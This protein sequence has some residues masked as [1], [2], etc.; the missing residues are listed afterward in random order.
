MGRKSPLHHLPILIIS[1]A[2]LIA[3]ITFLGPHDGWLKS[4]AAEETTT[5]DVVIVGAGISGL[6]AGDYLHKDYNIVVL[7]K[8][9]RPGG[10]AI[11]GH[12][13]GFTYAKGAEYIGKPYGALKR[14]LSQL[15]IEP[16]EIPSPMDAYYQDGKFY[17]GEEGIALMYID[18]CGLDNFNDFISTIKKYARNYDDIPDF[19][20]NSDLAKLDNISAKSWFEKENFPEIIIERYNIAAR[21]LFGANLGEISALSAIP[22]IAFEYLGSPTIKDVGSLESTAPKG[23]YSTG[24]YTFLGG[25]AEVTTALGKELGDRVWYGKTVTDVSKNYGK[26]VVTFVDEIG[27]EEVVF[28]RVVILA[29]PAP[30][31]LKI[32]PTLIIGEKKAIM[33]KIEYSTYLTVS[34]ISEEPIFEEAFDLAVPDEMFFTDVYDATWVEK[35]YSNTKRKEDVH[36]AVV[37]I[38]P[39]SYK[40]RSL[41]K[42]TDGEVV[43]NVYKDLEKIFPGVRENVIKY[44]VER[45]LY[46]FPVMT[47]GAY[48]RLTRLNLLNTG[49]LLLAG[50]YLIYPT[51]E[52]AVDSGLLAAE[53]AAAELGR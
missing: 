11:S 34:L 26:Y 27:E 36:I 18:K 44:E 40:D 37:Y 3:L 6:T 29:V 52:S 7:E 25:I 20:L 1:V 32:A 31:A 2:V 12:Y 14:I 13:K 41:I 51:I 30:V 46:S 10:R 45:F 22:E 9:Q 4:E 17:F 42:M 5:Y 19:D 23:K 15:K 35:Y 47:P 49:T 8:N 39:K 24:S 50:D 48:R 53:R 33:S 43:D 38:P 16:K 28:G 21:G